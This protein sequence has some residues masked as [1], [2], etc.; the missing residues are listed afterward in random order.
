MENENPTVVVLAGPLKGK[1]FVLSEGEFSIGRETSNWL[2]VNG[3]LIS[4]QHALIKVES[5]HFS[6]M[7]MNSRNGTFVNA[8]PI[9]ERELEAGDRIQIGDSPLLFLVGGSDAVSGVS[10]DD[11]TFAQPVRFDEEELLMPSVVQLRPEDSIY[12]N[13][14]TATKPVVTER[15]VSDLRALLQ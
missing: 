6:I 11:R 8:V 10:S 15:T 14:E 5:G 12:L 3:K 13:L 2:C 4:R 7:D 9:R 1:T